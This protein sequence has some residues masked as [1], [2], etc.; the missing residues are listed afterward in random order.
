MPNNLK[1]ALFGTFAVFSAKFR[2]LSLIAPPV[3]FVQTV[4]I[5]LENTTKLL[6]GNLISGS[7]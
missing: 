5:Y 2:L 6:E 4:K 1:S 3:Q 7:Y